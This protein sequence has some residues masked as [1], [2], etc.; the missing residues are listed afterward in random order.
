LTGSRR[1]DLLLKLVS[2]R[3][4]QNLVPEWHLCD[5]SGDRRWPL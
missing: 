5:L 1:Q 2:V 4:S 3:F